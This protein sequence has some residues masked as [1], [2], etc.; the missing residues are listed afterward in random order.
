MDRRAV[1]LVLL[2]V[3]GF[4]AGAIIA[5]PLLWYFGL[6][7]IGILFGQARLWFE[8]ETYTRFF[9]ILYIYHCLIPLL[10]VLVASVSFWYRRYSLS[11]ILCALCF[12]SIVEVAMN[13]S[14]LVRDNQEK[15]I[16]QKQKLTQGDENPP[17]GY[18]IPGPHFVSAGFQETD[19][20]YG[21]NTI[22]VSY[23]TMYP[24]GIK[25]RIHY[26]MLGAYSELPSTNQAVRYFQFKGTDGN[27]K[28]LIGYATPSGYGAYMLNW[29]DKQGKTVII[30]VY[31]VPKSDFTP[32]TMIA[33]L[34]ELDA[35]K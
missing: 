35:V 34:S 20:Y 7:F 16:E 2:A 31:D 13:Y 24:D 14:S 29:K 21:A 11:I 22:R 19:R 26:R 12:V 9:E 27:I 25:G 3:V 30:E 32:D 5:I 17:S 33:M 15:K 18:M 4:L 23:E 10:F 8:L 28:E 1:N 6:L